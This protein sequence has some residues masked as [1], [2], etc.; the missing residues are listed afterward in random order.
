M[1]TASG[2]AVLIYLGSD[3]STVCSTIMATAL[4]RTRALTSVLGIDSVEPRPIRTIRIGQAPEPGAGSKQNKYPIH[5]IA[6]ATHAI[7][8]VLFAD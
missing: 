8:S 4:D 1:P 3:A 7:G 6:T 5:A 2:R